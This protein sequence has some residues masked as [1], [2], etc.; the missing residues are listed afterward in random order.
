MKTYDTDARRL[1][2]GTFWGNLRAVLRRWLD[3]ERE[4]VSLRNAVGMMSEARR[5][6]AAEYHDM[7]ELNREMRA[8]ALRLRNAPLVRMHGAPLERQAGLVGPDLFRVKAMLE[9]LGKSVGIDLP[10]DTEPYAETEGKSAPRV[11][12]IAIV[13]EEKQ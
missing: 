8:D 9:K 11:I 10:Y 7:R 5:A 1:N 12:G 13:T 3:R 6:D 2:V 4:L